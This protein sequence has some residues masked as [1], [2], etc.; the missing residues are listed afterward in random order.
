MNLKTYSQKGSWELCGTSKKMIINLLCQNCILVLTA[1]VFKP[2]FGC[3][4]FSP[5]STWQSQFVPGSKISSQRPFLTQTGARAGSVDLTVGSLCDHVLKN[6]FLFCLSLLQLHKCFIS[7][8]YTLLTSELVFELSQNK[9][10]MSLARAW[11]I[12][13]CIENHSSC[14]ANYMIKKYNNYS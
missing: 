2:R 11:K 6:N 10:M 5:S 14:L 9:A 1:P 4:N 8:Y 7:S 3:L 13:H 12:K